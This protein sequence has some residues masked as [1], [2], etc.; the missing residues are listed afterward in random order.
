MK[1]LV[2]FGDSFVEGEGDD[3]N[4]GGWV[5]RISARMGPHKGRGGDGWRIYNLGVSGDTINRAFY[6]VGE[7]VLREP[8]VVVFGCGTNDLTRYTENVWEG[9]AEY[10]ACKR[11]TWDFWRLT[12]SALTR[13]CPK[14][15]VYGRFDHDVIGRAKK[16]DSVAL[17]AY[18]QELC[19]EFC[20]EYMASPVELGDPAYL[21]HGTHPNAKGYDV[22][23]AAIEGK[24]KGVGW[25]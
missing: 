18:I 23:A 22:L 20:A 12:L 6:R 2:C 17:N 7:V 4:I 14:V 25:L 24:L 16:D 10:R 8:N 21:S 9:G 19:A 11:D 5:G 3:L 1:T 13:L 15:L